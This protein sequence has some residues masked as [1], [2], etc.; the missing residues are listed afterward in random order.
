MVRLGVGAQL[1]A[2]LWLTSRSVLP[3]LIFALHYAEPSCGLE[4]A[5]GQWIGGPS[6]TR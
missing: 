3:P 5:A 6:W 1:R 2:A 4:Q